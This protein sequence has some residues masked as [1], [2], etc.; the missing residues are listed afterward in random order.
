MPTGSSSGRT[1]VDNRSPASP[2]GAA[3]VEATLEVGSQGLDVDAEGAQQHRDGLVVGAQH[4]EGDVLGAD[5]PRP[6]AKGLTQRELEHLLRATREPD[7]ATRHE[8]AASRPH[9][10]VRGGIRVER[11][12]AEL[13]LDRKSVV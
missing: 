9:L 11:A 5:L 1:R 4:A 2:S 8:P 13:A 6:G 12:L 10:V 3:P 7:V